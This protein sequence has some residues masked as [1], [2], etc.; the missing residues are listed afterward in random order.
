MITRLLEEKD[1]NRI[2]EIECANFSAPWTKESLL[3]E[4]ISE[5]SHY[6]VVENNGEVIGYCG[7]WKIFDEGHITNIA[8]DQPYQGKGV[9]SRLIKEMLELGKTLDVVSY[10][11]EVRVS[12]LQAIGLYE[13]F[14][15]ENVGIRKNFYD[16]PNEDAMIMWKK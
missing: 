16:N 9:G 11:L 2:H 4:I 14:G 15:F 10:T 3:G 8:V 5:R 13:K 7:F 1:I 6:I 12:N